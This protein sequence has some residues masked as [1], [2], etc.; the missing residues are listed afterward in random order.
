M[1]EMK[2]T[3]RNHSEKKL[4]RILYNY[5][6]DSIVNIK[7]RKN[8]AKTIIDKEKNQKNQFNNFY[9]KNIK[10]KEKIRNKS[11]IKK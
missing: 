3:K 7:R 4:P 6:R 10:W 11:A 9:L 8:K 1:I 5:K 2:R